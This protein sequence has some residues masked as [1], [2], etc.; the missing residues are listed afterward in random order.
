MTSWMR[1]CGAAVLAAAA[2]VLAGCAGGYLLDN[3]VQTF[4]GLTAVPSN[5]GYRFE[6]LPSQQNPE[7]AQVEALADGALFRAGF[8]RDDAAPQYGVQVSARVQRVLSPYADPWDMGFGWGLGFGRRGVGIGFG[9]P[10]G[11]MESPWYQREV[12]IVVRELATQRVVYE[13]HALNAGPWLDNNG[14]LAAM[15]GA[16]LQGFPTPP[17]GPRRVD[18]QMGNTK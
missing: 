15:F 8:K 2:M 17:P 4:S 13:T 12:G 18:I 6:R 16:A 1:L 10:L 5:L 11:R 14:V 7:Q 9:G 3:Q